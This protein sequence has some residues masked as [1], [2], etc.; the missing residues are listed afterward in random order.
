MQVK[1]TSDISLEDVRQLATE[2]G[3]DFELE[4]EDHQIVYKSHD[5]PSWVRLFANADW[6]IKLLA[7]YASLY[8]AEIAKEAGKET[9]KNRGKIA[10]AA[11]A[12]GD[13][14]KQFAVGLGH[15][16][17]RLPRKTRLEIALPF[18]DDYDGT[19]LELTGSTVDELSPQ[20]ALFV[21]H[22]PT[23][24]DLMRSEGLGRGS[25]ATGIHLTILSDLSLHVAWQDGSLK[26]QTRVLKI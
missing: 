8:F 19:I 5:A 24:L 1:S 6:W 15:L 21:H 26:K 17:S 16:R 14:I 25:I 4:V 12:A 23:L 2:L 9:W 10:S 18:P 3:A 13:R 22:L 20:V 7:A 11:F